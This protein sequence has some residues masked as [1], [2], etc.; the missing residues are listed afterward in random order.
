MGAD[1]WGADQGA[2]LP[3]DP[4]IL[5]AAVDPG[6]PAAAAAPLAA[7][8]GGGLPLLGWDSRGGFGR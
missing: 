4:G 2:L 1:R 5:Q 6:V 7:G 8:A 3:A